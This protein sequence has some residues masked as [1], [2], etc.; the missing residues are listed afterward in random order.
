MFIYLVAFVL[1]LVGI[2]LAAVETGW[3]K[4][5]IRAL[6]VRQA[7]QYLTATLTIGRLDGSL[8]R[9][10]QLGDVT[11]A[12]D[13]QSIIAID[14]I[15]VSYSL[16]EI[17]Q[18]GVIIKRVRLVRPRVQVSREADGRWNLGALVKRDAREQERTGPGRPI[19]IQSIEI[20]DGTVLL[21]DPLVF[22]DAHVPS[23]FT[24]LDAQMAFAYQPVQ[25]TLAF[26][27]VSWIGREPELD[28]TRLSGHDRTGARRIFLR[29]PLRPDA[30]FRLHAER[31]H[32][33][34]ARSDRVRPPGARDALHVSGMGRGPPRPEQHRGRLGL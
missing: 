34:G 28:M 22:G 24:K 33:P 25:W 26:A 7:N 32:P 18:R 9:G 4:N 30:A 27:R 15:A 21:H 2:G 29:Q 19:Q 8:L 11:V 16:R 14:D 12:R 23:S 3:A 1:V 31:P 5:Q 6:I 17:W 10:I 13:G 20:D